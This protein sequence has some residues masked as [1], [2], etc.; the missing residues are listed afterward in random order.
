M[1][2]ILDNPEILSITARDGTQL[3]AAVYKPDGGGP[4]P[5]LFAASPYRFDNNILPASPQF[6]WRETGPIEFY[7]DRGYAYV[8]LDV[9]GSGRSNGK[10]DFLGL[11][12]QTDLYDSIEFVSKQSWSSG[13]VGSIGQSY[14]CMLQW[15]MGIMNP[16]SLKCIAAHDGLNDP[17]R[18]GV[19]HGGIRCDFFP[20]YWWH[21]NRIINANPANSLFPKNQTDD[22]DQLLTSHPLLD[23]FWK[24]RSAFN[25][26][27]EIT[28]P[29]YSSGVWSKHQLHTR[30]NIEAYLKASGPK[31][32]RMSGAQNAWVAAIEYSSTSFHEK[33]FLPFFDHYL[34]G[35]DTDYLSRPDVEFETRSLPVKKLISSTWPP[36]NKEEIKFSL[37][38][39]LSHSVS[40]LNDGSL[41]KDASTD[42]EVV[43]FHYP[44]EGWLNGVVGFGAKG[45]SSG[46]DP[47]RR[48]LTFTSLPLKNDL[49]VVGSMTLRLFLSSTLNDTDVFVKIEEQFPQLEEERNQGINPK[50]ENVS[51]GWLRASHR[52]LDHTQSEN[53]HILH[54]HDDEEALVPNNIYEL[55]ISIEPTAYV[56]KKSHRIRLEIANGD[57]SLTEILWTHYYRPNKMGEDTIYMGAQ[58]NSELIMPII[59]SSD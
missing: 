3:S 44:R 17:Y 24:E 5:T 20:G 58:Y 56:F 40:S 27:G 46:F 59:P 38:S 45:P 49:F 10:F 11:N 39:A 14:Y 33:V 53:N 16:P 15:W 9:R 37:S 47:S 13:K 25:R 19:Y 57:S 50:S 21:Q 41:V 54:C 6:L 30:G 1:K 55:L 43:K 34:K 18:A 52:K 28:T 51:R 8:H 31:K 23:D 12:D 35:F 2:S 26:L 32:L 22:L 7:V 36:A 29:L 42:L 48:V 4:F